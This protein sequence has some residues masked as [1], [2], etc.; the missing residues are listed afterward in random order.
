MLATSPLNLI[1]EHLALIVGGLIVLVGLLGVG[2]KDVLRFSPRRVRAIASV[3]FRQS[4]RRRVLWITPLVILGVIIVSQFQRPIDGQDAVRQTT[5][6]CL[7]AT[8][9]LVALVIIV[10]ACTNL[11]RE[12]D[13]RV[14][15]TVATKPVTRLEIILG[16]IVGFASVSG[17]ILL[18]MGAFTAGYL[19]WQDWRSRLEIKRELGAGDAPARATLAY[20]AREGTLHARK[21]GAPRTLNIYAHR[22]KDANDR[23]MPGGSDRDSSEIRVKFLI[24]PAEIPAPTPSPDGKPVGAIYVHL[25]VTARP[26]K[27]PAS[28]ATT[29][30]KRKYFPMVSFELLNAQSE[31]LVT[32]PQ[33][34]G[35]ADEKTRPRVRAVKDQDFI[36]RAEENSGRKELYLPIER[37]FVE[38]WL[39]EGD[40]PTEVYVK[41]GGSSGYDYRLEGMELIDRPVNPRLQWLPLKNPVT[42]Q[43]WVDY[44]GRRAQSGQQLKG[45]QDE[46]SWVAMYEFRD[47][48][49]G[50]GRK[51]YPVEL[52]SIIEMGGDRDFEYNVVTLEFENLK[53]GYNSEL[54]ELYPES[55]RP[56]YVE[57]PGNAVEGGNFNVYVR[58]K[59]GGWLTL[60]EGR[61]STLRLVLADEPFVWN[62]LKSLTILWLMSLLISIVAIFCSTFLSW[63]IA[64]VL[65]LVILSGRWG[66]EQLSDMLRPGIG[67]QIVTDMFRGAGARTARVVS[68]SVEALTQGLN[69][70]ASVLPELSRF[71][72]IEDIQ[73]GISIDWRTMLS[74]LEVAVGFGLPLIVL[75][76]VFLRYKEVA[77]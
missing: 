29:Q 3:C 70:T 28:A 61:F 7:F 39:T 47:L 52:R 23:W 65:T 64:V 56:A 44:G 73:A 9:M 35:R 69:M 36:W 34:N 76:Y 68:Q 4:I 72:A 20:Y 41:M 26:G 53:T 16:K 8:G 75:S 58:M 6:Y 50:S 77:P 49:A 60:R 63:P 11:P 46:D 74:A 30:P 55:N 15:Y 48:P 33:M 59:T 24:N 40:V 5:G 17:C 14:M 45:T 51:S 1:S 18:I 32:W 13:S 57:V 21:L 19:H 43:A 54:I 12:I 38:K 27:P 22:P 66:T 62:L 71:A 37:E 31:A 67:N 42:G 2:L 25:V 10:L